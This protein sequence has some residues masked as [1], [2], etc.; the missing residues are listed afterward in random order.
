M[1]SEHQKFIF[2]IFTDFDPNCVKLRQTE[3]KK[4]IGTFFCTSTSLLKFGATK[5]KISNFCTI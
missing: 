1:F 3:F 2:T 4:S 5:L